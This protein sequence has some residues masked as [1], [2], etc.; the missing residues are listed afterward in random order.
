MVKRS[1]DPSV[2]TQRQFHTCTNKFLDM[3][4]FCINYRP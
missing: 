2:R 4:A 3:H 1:H